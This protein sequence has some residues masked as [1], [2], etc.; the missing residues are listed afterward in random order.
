MSC[1]PDLQ[2]WCANDGRG[3]A[4]LDV[5]SMYIIQCTIYD[6]KSTS[7]THGLPAMMVQLWLDTT[8]TFCLRYGRAATIRLKEF[9]LFGK[10]C[11]SWRDVG[12]DVMSRLNYD[13][14]GCFDESISWSRRLRWHKSMHMGTPRHSK[15]PTTITMCPT[16]VQCAYV[17]MQNGDETSWRG[18][19]GT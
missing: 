13:D 6:I 2:S 5:Q 9:D 10:L 18:T 17:L 14:D 8:E 4:H 15:C 12:K 16:A 3:K 11:I 1:V 19:R 7:S